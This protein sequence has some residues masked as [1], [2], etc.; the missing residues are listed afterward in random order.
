MYSLINKDAL[1]ELQELYKTIYKKIGQEL[2][3]NKDKI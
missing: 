3:A 1:N 2:E